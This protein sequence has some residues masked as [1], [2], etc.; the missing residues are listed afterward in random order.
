MSELKLC[1]TWN[2]LSLRY[3]QTCLS[4]VEG[5]DSSL[6][7]E[8]CYTV[9]PIHFLWAENILW[10]FSSLVDNP[11]RP[12]PL[13]CLGFEITFRHTTLGKDPLDEASACRRDLYLTT[14]NT[15]NRQAFI[16]QTGFEPAIPASELAAVG[17]GL[18]V[19][20]ICSSQYTSNRRFWK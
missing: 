5:N 3:R 7:P 18:V 9:R 4:S 6:F 14:H 20:G 8:S 12:G 13:L 19:N 16:I 1:L 10:I 2:T 15:H 11:N 17:F